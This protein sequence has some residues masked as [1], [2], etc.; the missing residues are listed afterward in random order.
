MGVLDSLAGLFGG[1]SAERDDAATGASRL[2]TD[3]PAEDR[4]ESPSDAGDETSSMNRGFP[5]ATLTP[6]YL[7]RLL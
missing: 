3:R 7:Q 6:F 4:G 5:T 1:V 2:Q